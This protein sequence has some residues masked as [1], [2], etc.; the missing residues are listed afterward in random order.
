MQNI[1]SREEMNMVMIKTGR[2]EI[3]NFI[4]DD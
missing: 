3:R 2:L 4:I 1:I